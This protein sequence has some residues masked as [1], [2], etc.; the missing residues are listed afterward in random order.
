MIWLNYL[1]FV[2]VSQKRVLPW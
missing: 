1:D 2:K